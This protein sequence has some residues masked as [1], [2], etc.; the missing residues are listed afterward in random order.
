MG[1][2]NTLKKEDIFKFLKKGE[3]GKKHFGDEDREY[4]ESSAATGNVGGL[5]T[6]T[7]PSY[8]RPWHPGNSWTSERHD[9]ITAFRDAGILT[10]TDMTLESRPCKKNHRPPVR[11]YVL[12]LGVEME[13]E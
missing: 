11:P 6:T 5:T 2:K 7:F 3:I 13:M 12:G 1:T 8:W 4:C 10:I 9:S